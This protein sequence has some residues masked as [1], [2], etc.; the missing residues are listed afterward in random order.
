MNLFSISFC[1]SLLLILLLNKFMRSN[2]SAS[3]AGWAMA[4]ADGP[5]NPFSDGFS[6]PLL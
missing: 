6:F 5:W 2:A 3:N 1:S 4:G